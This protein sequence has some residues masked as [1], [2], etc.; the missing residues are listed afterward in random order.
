MSK[1]IRS[2]RTE[3]RVNTL[4]NGGRVLNGMIPY[5][6]KSADLGNFVEQISPGAFAAALEAGADVLCL[7][8]HDEKILLGRT[9][10]KTMTL[11][12]SPEGLRYSV[13]L[14]GTTQASDLAESVDRGD[15]D[16][17][18]FG[19]VCEQDKWAAD[20]NGKAIRTLEKVKLFEISPGS[21]SA[22]PASSVSTRSC[23]PELRSL[24]RGTTEKRH[25]RVLSAVTG[26]R[27][28]ITEDKLQ[29]ICAVLAARAAGSTMS[30][31]EI[32]AAMMGVQSSAPRSAGTV[33]IIPIYGTISNR[34]NMFSEFSGGTSIQDLTAS[35]RH[36]LGDPN[37]K[38]IVFDDDS[39]GG[40]V[41]G[42]PELAAEIF[43]ARGQKPIIAV[44]NTMAASAAYWLACAAETLVVAPSGEVGSI[45]VYMMHE[46]WS[47]AMAKEGVE[48]TFIKAGKYKAEGNP[49]Q[50]L[51]KGAAANW[52]KGVDATYEDFIT[53]VATARGVKV[54]AV[55]GGF[56]EGRM[57]MAKDAL[58][59]GMVDRIATLDQILAELGATDPRTDGGGRYAGQETIA[60]AIV[61]GCDCSEC[62]AGNCQAC[63]DDDCDDPGC[64]CSDGDDEELRTWRANV[65]LDLEVR[66][67]RCR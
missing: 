15:I 50:P 51:S 39:P 67:R 19:F 45:G 17:C 18:S 66:Q 61:C 1:E 31:D 49:Y 56:G 55:S 5:N 42:V 35:F 24:L 7:R 21:F 52:Q 4:A 28:A 41:D 20:G 46:D 14:P 6:S 40:T 30:Q 60:A 3:V 25:L 64:D 38:A 37:V 26:S 29:T 27:W 16:S 34:A 63:A 62:R 47:E 44:A 12:D 10:S 59:E 8:D 53:F 33:A 32:R 2:F 11:T 13:N 57:M 43:A 9:K 48:V 58:A 54:N 36:A 23:P 65:A 22:Y